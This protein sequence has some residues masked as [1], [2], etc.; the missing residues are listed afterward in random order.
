MAQGSSSSSIGLI[1]IALVNFFLA[2]LT[3]VCLVI[4]CVALLPRIGWVPTVYLALV[5]ILLMCILHVVNGVG[6]LRRRRFSGFIL[7]NVLMV[8]WIVSIAVAGAWYGFR[9][10]TIYHMVQL[11]YAVVILV[12]L[13][14][15]YKELFART[16]RKV[17]QGSAC[18]YSPRVD[19][20][21]GPQEK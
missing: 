1:L 4:L 13:N 19:T 5:Y 14:G 3:G 17:E 18:N 16:D 11:L 20:G 2:G 12:V 6:I 7:G 8:L 15:P 10:I 9:V 21:L